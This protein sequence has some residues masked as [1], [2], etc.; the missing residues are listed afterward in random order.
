MSDKNTASQ[1][2]IGFTGLLTIVFITLKLIG[3]IDWNWWWVLSPA[4]I[5]SSLYVIVLLV[6]LIYVLIKK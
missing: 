6:M 2:G 4:I 5:V 1:G 3:K